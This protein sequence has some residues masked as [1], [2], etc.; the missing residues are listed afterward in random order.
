MESHRAPPIFRNLQKL[1][2]RASRQLPQSPQLHPQHMHP[3]RACSLGLPRPKAVSNR[4][5]TRSRTRPPSLSQTT[6]DFARLEL[7]ACSNVNLLLRQ[8]LAISPNSVAW[9]E[10]V[11]SPVTRIRSGLRPSDFRLARSARIRTK[12]SF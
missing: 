8:P 1:G 11:R 3:N 12:A 5:L 2:R 7:Y 9:P 6:F 10:C 4:H